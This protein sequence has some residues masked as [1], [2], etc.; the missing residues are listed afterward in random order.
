MRAW[1][2]SGFDLERRCG[3]APAGGLLEGSRR[4]FGGR[5]ALGV[6]ECWVPSV[7]QAARWLCFCLRFFACIPSAELSWTRRDREHELR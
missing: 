6:E 2:A 4:R 5:G 3:A 7:L 1:A